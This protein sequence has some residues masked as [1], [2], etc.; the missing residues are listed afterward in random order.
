MNKYSLSELKLADDLAFPENVKRLLSKHFD[1]DLS[2]YLFTE[3]KSTH[4]S[5]I[6]SLIFNYSRADFE[7]LEAGFEKVINELL[8]RE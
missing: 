7:T 3:Y 5:S 2:W 4:K 6:I 1:E 8:N